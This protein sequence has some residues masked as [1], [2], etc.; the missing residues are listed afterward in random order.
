MDTYI[1]TSL[2]RW[3]GANSVLALSAFQIVPPNLG[4][5]SC[6]TH[7]YNLCEEK[8]AVIEVPLSNPLFFDVFY[9]IKYFQ[10]FM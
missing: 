9:V 3:I 2:R 10:N 8:A 6:F 7:N 5:V 1:A 4:T